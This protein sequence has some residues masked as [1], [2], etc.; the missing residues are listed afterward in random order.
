MEQPTID[1]TRIGPNNF[2]HETLT[3]QAL[4]AQ[5]FLVFDPRIEEVKPD[6][7]KNFAGQFILE[8][9][10]SFTYFNNFTYL[11]EA[12]IL[13]IW[14]VELLSSIKAKKM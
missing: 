9:K 13:N 5:T 12:K 4:F 7:L 14:I 11:L 6:G 3:F 1:K 8:E 2:V 10:F